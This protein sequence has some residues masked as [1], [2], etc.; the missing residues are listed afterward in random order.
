MADNG[1]GK[2]IEHRLTSLE[3]KLEEI[4][5]TIDRVEG[6]LDGLSDL[7]DDMDNRITKN[8]TMVKVQF[9]LIGLIIT[10]GSLLKFFG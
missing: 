1:N 5:S 6:K 8:S 2:M 9:W 7:R 4:K 3:V 10:A